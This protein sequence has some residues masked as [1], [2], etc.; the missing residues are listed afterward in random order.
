M[1]KRTKREGGKTMPEVAVTQS[2]ND[3]PGS[4]YLTE[5]GLARTIS[6]DKPPSKRTLRR[7]A[8]LRVG[9]PR[10]AIGKQILYRRDAVHEW[11]RSLET[12]APISP[13]RRKRSAR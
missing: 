5:E 8:E 11:L 1:K 12:A 7:W 13:T 9:P 3:M 4:D 2:K 6:P 10:I